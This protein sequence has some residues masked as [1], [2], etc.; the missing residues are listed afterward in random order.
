MRV[1]G[2]LMFGEDALILDGHVPTGEGGHLRT[3][4]AMPCIEWGQQKVRQLRLL[5]AG[6]QGCMG[7]VV[8]I[9]ECLP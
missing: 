9:V 2:V 7:H 3:L 8:V 1:A 5:V 6:L 4:G